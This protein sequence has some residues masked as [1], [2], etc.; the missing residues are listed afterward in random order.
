MPGYTDVCVWFQSFKYDALKRVLAERGSTIEEKLVEKLENIYC[1]YVPRDQREK[2]EE[3]IAALIRGEQEEAARRA[4]EQYRESVL[5]VNC[6]GNV[7]YWKIPTAVSDV[8]IA[9]KLRQALR[10]TKSKH[11]IGFEALIN[12]LVA[13]SSEEFARVACMFLQGEKPAA[14]AVAL[15]FDRGLITLAG[16]KAGYLTY[17]MKDVSTAIYQAERPQGITE[18]KVA[19]RF[20]QRLD[21]KTVQFAPWSGSVSEISV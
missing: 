7:R 13:I 10:A 9:R 5:K 4:A 16:I 18:Q 14:N 21:G 6:D 1:E 8:F 3:K 20:Y 15:D 19:E 17:R 11:D 12:G 2:I